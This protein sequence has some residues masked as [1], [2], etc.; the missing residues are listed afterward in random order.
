[1]AG[2]ALQNRCA[3]AGML[4]TH[5]SSLTQSRGI[6]AKRKANGGLLGGNSHASDFNVLI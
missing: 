5:V 6:S 4:L 1:M 3:A 2:N